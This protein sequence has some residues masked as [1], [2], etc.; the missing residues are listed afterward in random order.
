MKWR[1]TNNNASEPHRLGGVVVT[2]FNDNPHFVEIAIF[3]HK[4]TLTLI[5]RVKV[6]F[7]PIYKGFESFSI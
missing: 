4:I 5:K 2:K 7:L 6:I 1:A 3:S